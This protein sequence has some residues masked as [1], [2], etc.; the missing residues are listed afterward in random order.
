MVWKVIFSSKHMFNIQNLESKKVNFYVEKR[1]FKGL[2]GGPGYLSQK[3]WNMV[4][5]VIF[6]KR[7]LDLRY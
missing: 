3:V 5:K 6:S 1:D 4:F 7:S 2:S